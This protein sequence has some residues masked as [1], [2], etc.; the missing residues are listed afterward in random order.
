MSLPHFFLPEQIFSNEHDRSFE[1]CLSPDDRKHFNA[2]R[3]Q[4]GEHIA[5]IDA[6]ANYYECQVE[7]V[8][9]ECVL[10]SVAGHLDATKRPNITLVQG[11]A[12]G[13]K[14]D[15]VFCHA[16]EVGIK[17]FLPL[18]CSRSI[19]K[20]DNKKKL[21]RLKRWESL[22]KSAAMQSGQS[23]VPQVYEPMTLSQAQ[24]IMRGFDLLIVF[25]EEASKECR[26]DHILQDFKSDIDTICDCSIGVVV[27]PEGGIS[28]EE[29]EVMKTYNCNLRIATLG[30]SILRTETAGLL[31]PAL[32]MYELER[33]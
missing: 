18:I 14:M 30:P 23:S 11:L 10:V 3:V 17:A 16:T 15:S 9:R 31:A 7:S 13:D 24:D 28:Q 32:V 26:L 29:I 4:S 27:G 22:V 21:S 8:S 1:L 20:L 5:V 19:V 2:L 33:L 12:K 25:W 6:D